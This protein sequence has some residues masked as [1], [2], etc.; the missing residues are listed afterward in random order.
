M[1]KNGIEKKIFEFFTLKHREPKIDP[2]IFANFFKTAKKL[3]LKI[4]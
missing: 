1:T 2:N 3:F 4:L